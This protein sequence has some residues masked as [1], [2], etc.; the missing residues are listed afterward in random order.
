[1]LLVL[2]WAMVRSHRSSRVD[3]CYLNPQKDEIDIE[4][5]SLLLSR[6]ENEYLRK[7]LTDREFRLVKRQ[8]V[9]LARRYLK[10]ISRNTRELIRA[11]DVAKSSSDL[12]AAR[13]AH[14]LMLIAFRVKVNL[15]IVHL[16]LLAEWLLP[17]LTLVAPPKLD[18]YREITGRVV[19]ILRRLQAEPSRMSI[20]G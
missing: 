5:L 10:A 20:T 9:L 15:P 12:E 19:F 2:L 6:K 13:A 3:A 4:V 16:Y 11:A 14:E 18:A 17:T 7:V 8:R 1:M